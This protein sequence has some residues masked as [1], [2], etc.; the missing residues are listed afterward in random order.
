MKGKIS[1]WKDDKGFGFI[2][3]HEQ[4]D[5]I[6]FHISDIKTKERRPKIDDLVEFELAQD[7]QK[8]RRAK[9]IIFKNSSTKP[10]CQLNHS[11][12]E[13]I[14]KTILD[15]IA[16]AFLFISIGGAAFYYK[17]Q[18]FNKIMPFGVFLIISV[19]IL[20][21]KRIP[22]EKF[23]TC[24]RCKSI[25]DFDKRTIQAWSEGF[26]KIYCSIC[27]KQWL[28]SHPQESVRNR[29]SAG[30]CLGFF[31]AMLLLPILMFTSIYQWF[32]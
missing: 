24:A 17:I 31:V 18:D 19:M 5:K 8:R 16:I 10:D 6:S 28:E 25:T 2:R 4:S 9:N 26:D 30:G 7:S 32:Y 21:R 11:N 23:F 15:Y 3:S 29:Q 22:K 20:L 14:K 27:H 13:P 1:D 12:I